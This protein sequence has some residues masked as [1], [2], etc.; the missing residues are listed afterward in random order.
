MRRV[1]LP[2]IVRT[3]IHIFEPFLLK[4]AGKGFV[5]WI[6]ETDQ[7]L[8]YTRAVHCSNKEDYFHH[9]LTLWGADHDAEG[10]E[11]VLVAGPHSFQFNYKLS[12]DIPSSFTSKHGKIRYYLRAFCTAVSGT[13]AQVEKELRVQETY[14]LN[15]DPQ[16]KLPVMVEAEKGVSYLCWTFPGISLRVS[17]DKGGFVP[18]EE[19]IITSHINNRTPKNVK[20]ISY[21]L[22]SEIKY[23]AFIQEAFCDHFREFVEKMTMIKTNPTVDIPPR[24]D[25]KIVGLL[26]LPS[27]LIVSDMSRCRIISVQYWLVVAISIPGTRTSVSVSAPIKIGTTPVQLYK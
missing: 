22:Y 1:S 24:N 9:I 21:S 14:N 8:D 25:T 11:Q 18:G 17:I 15:L 7:S 23:K 3:W 20:S 5:E 10:L 27:P 2:S 19:V 4:F 16:T 6:E 26:Q 12:S 13:L